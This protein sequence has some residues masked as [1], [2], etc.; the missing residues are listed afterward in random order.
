MYVH[1]RRFDKI[2][3]YVGK[4]CHGRAWDFKGRSKSWQV[5]VMQGG[6]Q[7]DIWYYGLTEQEA[8]DWE[9]N[10]IEFYLATER[11]LVNV[12]HNQE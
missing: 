5:C 3:F 12:H 2:P 6:L 9:K 1:R 11:P 10:L 8:F 4:G 7:V